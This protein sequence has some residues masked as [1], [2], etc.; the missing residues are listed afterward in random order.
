ME[1]KDLKEYDKSNF[2]G[3]LNTYLW[4]R[5][6]EKEIDEYKENENDEEFPKEEE[7]ENDIELV[8][9]KTKLQQRKQRIVRLFP[10]WSI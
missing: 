8:E 9:I 1:S 10:F 3:F 4:F 5:I 6:I 7:G 2:K